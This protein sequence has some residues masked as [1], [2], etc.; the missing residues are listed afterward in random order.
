MIIK[1]Q[2]LSTSYNK[3]CG[4]LSNRRPS[5]QRYLSLDLDSQVQSLTSNLIENNGSLNGTLVLHRLETL[6]PLVEL[7]CLVDDARNLDLSFVCCAG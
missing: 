3:V 2:Q 4:M 1:Y 6:L 5:G 7:E